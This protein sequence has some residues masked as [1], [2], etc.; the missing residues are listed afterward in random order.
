MNER[1]GKA[2]TYS[3]S[4]IINMIKQP[5][6]NVS[7]V[8]F[9]YRHLERCNLLASILANEFHDDSYIE[10]YKLNEN[11]IIKRLPNLFIKN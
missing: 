4:I 9:I 2:Y 8:I 5:E 1:L 6:L 3:M 7:E 10:A 11:E